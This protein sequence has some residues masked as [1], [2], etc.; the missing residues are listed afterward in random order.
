[1]GKDIV[2]VIPH[3][4]AWLWL[5]TCVACLLRNPPR[6]EGYDVWVAIVDNSPWSPAI[7]GVKETALGCLENLHIIPNY[8]SNRFHASALD[9]VVESTSFD[10]MMALETA[11]YETADLAVAPARF[12]QQIE[13]AKMLHSEYRATPPLPRGYSW[14]M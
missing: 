2:V 7:K 1:V 10:Y 8:K 13:R 12:F 14:T 5:Q 11:A 6:A 9:C 4:H 3:S